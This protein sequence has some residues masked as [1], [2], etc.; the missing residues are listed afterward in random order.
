[1]N[2]NILY[3]LHTHKLKVKKQNEKT[4]MSSSNTSSPKSSYTTRFRQFVE[5]TSKI[6]EIKKR[7]HEDS[8]TNK[9]FELERYGQ[10]IDANFF[11]RNCGHG[12]RDNHQT[13]LAYDDS[14][15][16]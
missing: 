10:E 4:K 1:M 5:E 8:F 12:V 14:T 3:S 11:Q 6:H 7:T 13:P 15:T 16:C 2:I 9:E